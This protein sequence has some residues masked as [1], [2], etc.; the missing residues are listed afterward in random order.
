MPCQ[1]VENALQVQESHLAVLYVKNPN[2][3]L[4]AVVSSTL[5]HYRAEDV[6]MPVCVLMMSDRCAARPS[7]LL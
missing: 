3:M 4:S 7:S 2:M 6:D 1:V 5:L